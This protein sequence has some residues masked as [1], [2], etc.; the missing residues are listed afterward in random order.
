M[1]SPPAGIGGSAHRGVL[2]R[3]DRPVL[4]EERAEL[5][6]VRASRRVMEVLAELLPLLVGD[7]RVA[8]GRAGVE[9]AAGAERREV[10]QLDARAR[11]GHAPALHLRRVDLL[12]VR[13]DIGADVGAVDLEVREARAVALGV[14]ARRC[15]D[16]QPV[17]AIEVRGAGGHHLGDQLV[18]DRARPGE[19][20]GVGRRLG[21]RA[22]H[23]RT[24]DPEGQHPEGQDGQHQ[25]D[26]P[27]KDLTS[28]PPQHARQRSPGPVA[29]R[30][31]RDSTF[32]RDGASTWAWDLPLR[33]SRG[34]FS[35]DEPTSTPRAASARP[36]G[37]RAARRFRPHRLLRR[38][39]AHR[40]RPEDQ[41][42]RPLEARQ[43]L[44][45]DPR[46]RRH[47]GHDAQALGADD[48]PA[49][50]RLARR[51]RGG[52]RPHQGLAAAAGTC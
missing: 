24:A 3:R 41:A 17:D 8:A 20:G 39:R 27:R 45:V 10:E 38:R 50:P 34:I 52:H 32:V 12:L 21:V 11:L 33:G 44:R 29:E 30:G 48:R 42:A 37:P 26:Q 1:R 43:G 49:R 23:R 9:R 22:Q 14:V 46:R 4:L 13:V 15:R 25:H 40:G 2:V 19:R 35:C 28:L 47:D 7:V 5:D 36:L 18:A 51:L 31:S 16:E 6:H